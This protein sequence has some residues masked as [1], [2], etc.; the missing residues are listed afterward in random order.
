M[1]EERLKLSD[2]FQF[3]E[4]CWKA[5]VSEFNSIEKNVLNLTTNL[6]ADE[7]DG[8]KFIKNHRLFLIAAGHLFNAL[9][10]A[11]LDSLRI[12]TIEKRREH[13]TALLYDSL[14]NESKK[15]TLREFARALFPGLNKGGSLRNENGETGFCLNTN[16]RLSASGVNTLTFITIGSLLHVWLIYTE[17]PETKHQFENPIWDIYLRQNRSANISGGARPNFVKQA[18]SVLRFG[19]DIGYIELMKQDNARTFFNTALAPFEHIP[20]VAPLDERNTATL[21]DYLPM[22]TGFYNRTSIIL[23]R[24]WY[25]VLEL[26]VENITAKISLWD[27][28]KIEAK[29][30]FLKSFGYFENGSNGCLFDSKEIKDETLDAFFSDHR[31]LAMLE[32]WDGLHEVSMI[33]KHGEQW[34]IDLENTLLTLAPRKHNFAKDPVLSYMTRSKLKRAKPLLFKFCVYTGDW[35]SLEYARATLQMHK[36]IPATK[37]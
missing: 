1:M 26:S 29:E 14:T 2:S 23:I 21:L 31:Q 18:V 5:A 27:L 9:V 24:A 37:R 19:A 8:L 15:A 20:Y 4:E 17:T 32:V 3:N 33:S 6:T 16:V 7:V 36:S 10:V 13:V 22:S 34:G 11:Y 12:H 35:Q 30:R 28:R 25:G